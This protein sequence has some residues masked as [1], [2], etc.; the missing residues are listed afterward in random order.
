M[1]LNK[2]I[3]KAFDYISIKLKDK[4][5]SRFLLSIFLSV[6]SLLYILFRYKYINSEIPFWYT[7]IWG[8]YQ[9]ASKFCIF[10][11]PLMMLAISLVG[12]LFVLLNKY[13]IQFFEDVVWLFVIS[14]NLILAASSFRIIQVAS[15]PFKSFINPLYIGLIPYVVVSFLIMYLIMPYFIDY[16]Q[17]KKLVTN[18]QIHDHPGMILQSPSARG[19]G[20]VYSIVFLLSAI[21]FIGFPKEFS[22]FYLSVLMVAVLGIID[23]YQNTHPSSSYRVLEN[24]SLRLFLLFLS[25]LPVVFSGVA[26]NTVSNPFGGMVNL[27]VFQ[28]SVGAGVLPVVPVVLTAVWVV[29]LMNVLSWSNGV[30]GQYAGIVGIASVLIAI[31]ALRFK[32]LQPFHMQIAILAAISAGASFGS[33]RFN[34]HPSQIMWGFGAVSAGLV[35]ASLAILAKTKIAVSVLI[36]LIPFL[37]AFVT[38]IRR[39]VQ[40]KNP[41]KGDRGHLHHILLNRGWSTNKVAIFYWSATAVFGLIGLLTPEE[42]VFKLMSVIAGVVMF[43]IILLNVSTVKRKKEETSFTTS[44]K[45]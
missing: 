28:I 5:L 8:D 18:P 23:D 11:I 40:K 21:L 10:L 15:L 44:I 13:Y 6:F 42:N 27:N 16:A 43:L 24:P 31:L 45:N 1:K 32:D 38:V 37:D 14:S 33:V 25:V 41:F 22:G 35:I 30:D 2:Q 29:W 20:F 3:K 17:R 34:W 12:L 7:K 39:L 19:G 9:L 26:I 36:I 4:T